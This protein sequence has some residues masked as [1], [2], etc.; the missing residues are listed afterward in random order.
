[1][2]LLVFALGW[3]LSE[4]N[5][6]HRSAAR[7]VIALYCVLALPGQAAVT[8]LQPHLPNWLIWSWWWNLFLAPY[9]VW[10]LL[11]VNVILL[12]SLWVA[13]EAASS[14]RTLTEICEPALSAA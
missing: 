5:G 6:E 2:G 12:H 4:I 3:A 11:A 1:L 13:A 9:A 10:V 7:A 14:K 8:R